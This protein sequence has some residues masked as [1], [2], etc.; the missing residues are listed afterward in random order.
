MPKYL[1]GKSKTT[2][3]GHLDKN[4]YK[5][6]D[7]SQAEPNPGYPGLHIGIADNSTGPVIPGASPG[8]PVGT[9]Y[10]LITVWGDNTATRY[11]KPI[12]GG[13]IPASFSVYEE[14]SLVG[15]AESITQLDFRGLG[16]GVTAITSGVAATITVAPPG[17]NGSV[18]FKDKV[19]YQK[20]NGSSWV[21]DYRDDFATATD[22]VY[23]GSVGILT[24][25]T[26][27]HIST[28]FTSD[29]PVLN[30]GVG[31]SIFRAVSVGTTTLVGIGTTNPEQNLDVQGNI[32]VSNDVYIGNDLSLKEAGTIID[33]TG[34]GGGAANILSRS[35]DGI[36][37]VPANQITAGAAGTVS[38]L[39]YHKPGGLLGGTGEWATDTGVIGVALVWDYTNKRVGIGSTLPQAL[40]DVLG[41]SIF[42]GITTFAGITTIT[43]E[44]LFT[45]QLYYSYN[46][47]NKLILKPHEFYLLQSFIFYIICQIIFL[48]NDASNDA[49]VDFG[50][51]FDWKHW[52]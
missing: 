30:I 15:S 1:S 8:L 23:N 18:L 39:Q 43:G 48:Y 2:A 41:N 35:T 28:D 13:Q 9:Q 52:F 47:I 51:V 49:F 36:E 34:S 42:T 5:Y 10:Q 11:W 44:A 27:L 14:G 20:W 26:G 45:K 3:V 38:F 25:G 16:I 32:K 4:R 29:S 17:N 40:F 46:Q 19:S 50:S 22:F 33:Y 37:W 12:G 24:V 7:I 31:G 6:L 21:T